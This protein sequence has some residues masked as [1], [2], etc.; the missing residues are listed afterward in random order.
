MKV[1]VAHRLGTALAAAL[2]LGLA[3]CTSERPSTVIGPVMPSVSAGSTHIQNDIRY[4]NTGRKPSTGRS[5]SAAITAEALINLDG[6]V[7]LVV[8]GAR[9]ADPATPAGNISKLQV[10]VFTASGRA[11]LTLNFNQLSA[12]PATVGLPALPGGALIQVTAHVSGIDGRRVDVVTLTGITPSLRPDLVAR[13]LQAPQRVIAGMPAVVSATVAEVGGQH[14]ATADC[15]LY[16][17]GQPADRASGIWV[18]AGDVVSCAFAPTLGGSGTHALR[19]ALEHVQPGDLNP[20]NNAADGSVEVLAASST[21]PDNFTFSARVLDGV[22]AYA[23]T[24]YTRWTDPAGLVT[25]E[26]ASGFH[27]NGRT[28]SILVSGSIGV[29]LPLPLASVE[30]AQQSGS[31][32]LQSARWQNVGQPAPGV[33]CA[34][35]SAA[36]GYVFYFCTYDAGFTTIGYA[37]NA[38]S[39][40]YESVDYSKVWNGAAYDVNTYVSNYTDTPATPLTIGSTFAFS[41][42]LTA[43]GTTY[44]FGGAVPLAAAATTD[45]VPYACANGT[46]DIY[47]LYTCA[48]TTST[49]SGITGSVTGSGFAS[50]PAA[51]LTP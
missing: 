17:D 5:G 24:F 23:D 31:R 27:A 25:Y 43:G 44:G 49:F 42:L 30:V 46:F 6:T 36:G 40:T 48:G 41:I 50:Q 32:L 19:I 13:D 10:R 1:V 11:L 35:Q 8:I 4:S 3:S 34:S 18:D 2:S 37:L 16:V 38:G 28:Q 33:A 15:V 45:D 47:A 20:A 22:M 21:P 14:G 7:S 29:K 51:R 26:Q 9:A 12:N 39:V